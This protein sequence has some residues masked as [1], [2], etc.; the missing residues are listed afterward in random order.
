MEKITIKSSEENIDFFVLEQ[1]KIQGIPYL[2]VSEDQEASLCYI[3][4]DL[5]GQDSSEAQYIFVEDDKE[6]EIVS[7]VFAELLED[8]EIDLI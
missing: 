1:T 5:S 7:Q 4:K 8:I 6:L 3:L 2:L